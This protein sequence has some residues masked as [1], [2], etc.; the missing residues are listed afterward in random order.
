MPLFKLIRKKNIIDKAA[1][2]SILQLLIRALSG[3]M[4][5]FLIAKNLT[6]DQQAIY[7]IFIS[8]SSIQWV[9]ELGMSTCLIQVLSGEKDK[10]R[11][12]NYLKFGSFYFSICSIIT[13]ILMTVYCFW[14]I[15]LDSNVSWIYSWFLYAI[16]ISSAIILNVL[17]ITEESRGSIELVYKSKFIASIFQS[18]VLI[19]SLYL[20]LSLYA[21]GISGVSFSIILLYLLR[22]NVKD[23]LSNL[24]HT[25]YIDLKSTFLILMPFQS[26][27]AIVWISGYLYWNFYN[28]YIYKYISV[29]LSAQFGLLNAALGAI[30]FSMIALLQTKRSSITKSI[31]SGQKN[32]TINAFLYTILLGVFGYFVLSISFISLSE[33]INIGD[34][35]FS[36]ILLI[37]FVILRMLS[38]L[39]EFNLIYLRCFRCEP[40]AKITVIAYL[41]IPLSSIISFE[42]FGHEGLFILPILFHVVF[43]IIACVKASFF[44]KRFKLIND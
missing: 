7:Y 42:L 11:I 44:I 27:T 22:N 13:F 36:G 15:G 8:V 12:I 5:I 17:V 30:S 41:I 38:M 28:I 9:F 20:G 34:R 26:R 2:Y 37:S 19:T 16:S 39:L 10:E 18:F 21:L 23:I 32:K 14:V 24:I 35:I 43:Y 29:D 1:L 33:I 25:K 3:P 31:F 40:L 6:V 4:S